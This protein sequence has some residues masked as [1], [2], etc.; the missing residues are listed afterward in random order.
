[1]DLRVKVLQYLSCITLEHFT[2]PPITTLNLQALQNFF[3]Q[4]F[5]DF[6]TS[7][8]PFRRFYRLVEINLFASSKHQRQKN[9]L[10]LS[11][12]LSPSTSA[13]F[14]IS[15]ALNPRSLFI[16]WYIASWEMPTAEA[17]RLTV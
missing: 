14:I 8:T 2:F 11:E 17:S 16:F 9:M 5:F 7:L 1:V 12:R 15:E 13:M 6:S 3:L 4:D 10:S